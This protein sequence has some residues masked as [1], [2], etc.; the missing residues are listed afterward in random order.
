MTTRAPKFEVPELVRPSLDERDAMVDFEAVSRTATD[1]DA[2][3]ARSVVSR[4]LGGRGRRT[5]ALSP[6]AALAIFFLNV[7]LIAPGVCIWSTWNGGIGAQYRA[8][9][10]TSMAAPHVSGGAAL[11]VARNPGAS[12]AQVRSALMAAGSFDWNNSD[13]PDGIKEPLLNAARF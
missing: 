12:P 9:Q 5:H 8:L 6:A 10:G 1:T 13:D 4:C 11:Y 3:A 2:I 7:D